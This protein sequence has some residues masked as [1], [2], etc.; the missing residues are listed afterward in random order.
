MGL[1]HLTEEDQNIVQINNIVNAGTLTANQNDWNPTGFAT[2]DIIRVDININNRVITG[3]VAPA[4]GVNR[5]VA[6]SNINTA[7]NDIRFSHNNAGSLAA[8]RFL[9]RDNTSKSVKPNETAVFWYD[10]I[11]QRWRPYNRVG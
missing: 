6:I 3:M 5:I 7:S 1:R 8:N 4:A 2:A 9:I 11:S 10:H